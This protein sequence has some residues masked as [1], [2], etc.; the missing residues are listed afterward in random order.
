MRSRER[1]LIYSVLIFLAASNAVLLL[2]ATGQPALASAAAWLEGLGPAESLT[3]TGAEGAKDLVLQNRKGR[4]S[5]TEDAFSRAYSTAFVHISTVLNKLMTS[6]SREEER[7]ALAD[8]LAKTDQDFRTRLEDLQ[9]RAAGLDQ[10]SPEFKSLF[11]EGQRVFN[12]YQA[13]SRGAMARRNQLDAEQLEKAYRELIEAVEV[14]GARD[15]IDI[16]YRFIPTGEEFKA[17]DRG[18]A[19]DAIRLRTALRYPE[20]LDITP[21]VLEELSLEA[22]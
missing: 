9:Q 6:T 3:L 11:E 18:E 5:W 14:V 2:S 4:L 19:L 15:G 12:E 10:E 21:E 8:E 22:E 1:T 17:S 16:V 7:Q 20:G 13:W